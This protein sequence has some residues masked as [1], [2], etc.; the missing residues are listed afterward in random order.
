[1]NSDSSNRS[2]SQLFVVAIA[3]TE[4]AILPHCGWT[5]VNKKTAGNSIDWQGLNGI[6]RRL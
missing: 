4:G 6:T 5:T 3:S 2:R 1:M